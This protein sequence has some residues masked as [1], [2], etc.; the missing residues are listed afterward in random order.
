MSLSLEKINDL[1]AVRTELIPVR[2]G[3][4]PESLKLI[5]IEFTQIALLKAGSQSIIKKKTE[6]VEG[7]IQGEYKVPTYTTFQYAV[8]GSGDEEVEIFSQCQDLYRFMSSDRFELSL[9][10][11]DPSTSRTVLGDI[12]EL[13]INRQDDMERRAFFDVRYGHMD[14]FSEDETDISVIEEFEDP[15]RVPGSPEL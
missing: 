1:I 9:R 15:E 11:L 8:V 10:A 3:Q 14:E 13:S 12:L 7:V 6:E 2:N 5:Y 4:N